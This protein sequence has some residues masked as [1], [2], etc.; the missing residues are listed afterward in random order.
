[1]AVANIWTSLVEER[2]TNTRLGDMVRT[3]ASADERIICMH[4]QKIRHVDPIKRGR[5]LKQH[6]LA[7]LFGFS[8]SLNMTA[9]AMDHFLFTKISFH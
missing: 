6:L 1:M 9:A 4:R 3:R 7:F 8:G 2:I 5:G